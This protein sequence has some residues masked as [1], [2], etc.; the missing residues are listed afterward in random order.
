M[1]F[2]SV[3]LWALPA[4][5]TVTSVVS[6]NSLGCDISDENCVAAFGNLHARLGSDGTDEFVKGASLNRRQNPPTPVPDVPTPVEDPVSPVSPVPITT[7]RP[8]T[9]PVVTNPTITT[10]FDPSSA[11]FPRTTTTPTT[12]PSTTTTTSSTSQRATSTV[13]SSSTSLV[14]AT[15]TDANGQTVYVTSTKITISTNAVADPNATSG[16]TKSGVEAFGKGKIVAIAVGG[17][18]AVLAA[19]VAIFTFRKLGLKPSDRFRDR[20]FRNETAGAGAGAGAAAAP[21]STTINN[22]INLPVTPPPPSNRSN[23]PNPSGTLD[24]PYTDSGS[25]TGSGSSP[26]P[27]SDA[28][29]QSRY[30][31][32]PA[33]HRFSGVPTDPRFSGLPYGAQYG[34][35][36]QGMTHEY[37]YPIQPH[38]QG[39]YGPEYGHEYGHEYGQ[40]YGQ[41]YEPHRQGAPAQAYG[42]PQHPAHHGY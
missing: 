13:T 41:N 14:V 25:R 9:E 32:V 15:S 18:L 40:E 30:S 27:G 16:Q 5:A 8:V 10:F 22:H 1:K 28:M 29:S 4:L 36:A 23:T 37:G 31:G 19:A 7:P 26:L 38:P 21:A 34:A 6:G 24:K 35:P 20:L 12:P 42:N 17:S 3:A 2:S 39:Q 33:D 11:L